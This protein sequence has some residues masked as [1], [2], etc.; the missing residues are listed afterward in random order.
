MFEYVL[1]EASTNTLKINWVLQDNYNDITMLSGKRRWA[2]G[3]IVIRSTLRQI[4][5][6]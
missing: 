3:D 5:N 4:Y 6:Q 1:I 2:M